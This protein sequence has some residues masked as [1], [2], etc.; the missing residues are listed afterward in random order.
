MLQ[1]DPSSG[2]HVRS[3]NKNIAKKTSESIH[4]LHGTISR[5]EIAELAGLPTFEKFHTNV[6]TSTTGES[7]NSSS[8]YNLTTQ[9]SPKKQGMPRSSSCVSL[10]SLS[11][12]TAGET[13][14]EGGNQNVQWTFNRAH[15]SRQN[16][17]IGNVGK[18][19]FF[20][21]KGKGDGLEKSE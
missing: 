4:G 8:H 9:A 5:L 20:N 7:L 2:N 15:S 1:F 21:K 3:V 10:T 16:R 13:P 11:L 19:I 12:Q 14:C 17:S 18:N 6:S